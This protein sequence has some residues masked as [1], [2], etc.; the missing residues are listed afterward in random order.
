MAPNDNEPNSVKIWHRFKK[1][2]CNFS[3]TS[4]KCHHV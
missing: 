3:V 1:N 2:N 4:L